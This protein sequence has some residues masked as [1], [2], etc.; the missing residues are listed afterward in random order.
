MNGRAWGTG[1][2]ECLRALYPDTSTKEVARILRRSL[3]AVY[4]RA[5]YLGL[6]KSAAYMA[7]P[8]ACRLRRG[9][10]VGAAYRFKPGHVPAN[11][12]V[13]GWQAGGRSAETQFKQG[14]RP[15]TWK[16]IGTVLPDAY[17]YLRKKMTETG[18]PPHD[19]VA[20]HVLLWQEAHGPIPPGHCLRFK[21]GN[22]RNVRRENL[23]LVSRGE[24]MRRNSIH[25]YPQEL[26]K[27]IRLA[28]RLRRTL[29]RKADGKEQAQGSS[30]PSLR[31]HRGVERRR[32]AYGD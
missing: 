2:D 27:T 4:G 26:K 1:E 23:E 5:W 29:R 3:F 22:K 11:K 13:K 15:H 20:V 18:Y 7:S 30:G 8:A 31:D 9:D 32:E 6:K 25:R 16:P 19:W 10:N 24:N 14:R 17:G 12:G 21:D 28:S